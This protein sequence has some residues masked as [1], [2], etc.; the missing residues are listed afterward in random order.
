ML[1]LVQMELKDSTSSLSDSST[2]AHPVSFE[3][4]AHETVS[5]EGAT[6]LADPFRAVFLYP[7]IGR[8][9]TA[10]DVA[11][12]F[13]MKLGTVLYQIKCFC[14]AGLLRVTRLEKRGGSSIKHYRATANA[15]FVPLEFSNVE[16]IEVLL[17]RWNQSLQPV[18]L[19][20]FATALKAV[21][22][23]WGVRISRDPG[24]RLMIA[25]AHCAERDWD[26]F[27][28]DSPVLMEGWFTDLRL[29][30]ADAKAFQAEL[31]GL[32]FKYLGREGTQRYIVKVALAPMADAQELPP[33]W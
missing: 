12:E 20:G 33:Q 18:Y 21:A 16:S 11:R 3:V 15:F 17:N 10:S 30:L 22:P 29:N 9:R 32:Y 31:V 1:N 27:A 23:S 25:P 4:A 8:E 6:L 5:G 26:F 14:R 2:S 7:F 13:D 19:R 24:G 28:P